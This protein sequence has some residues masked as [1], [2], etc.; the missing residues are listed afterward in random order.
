M[1]EMLSSLADLHDDDRFGLF[2][3]SDCCDSDEERGEIGSD[4]VTPAIAQ[5]PNTRQG[6]LAGLSSPLWQHVNWS[7][8]ETDSSTATS[9]ASETSSKLNIQPTLI[10]TVAA[11]D[12]ASLP[13]PPPFARFNRA[14]RRNHVLNID[15]VSDISDEDDGD[16][17]EQL[18]SRKPSRRR[19]HRIHWTPLRGLTL[20]F[21]VTAY[22]I[23]GIS[24]DDIATELVVHNNLLIV[25]EYAATVSANATLIAGAPKTNALRSVTE[26]HALPLQQHNVVNQQPKLQFAVRQQQPLNH[27]HL[28]FKQQAEMERFYHQPAILHSSTPGRLYYAVALLGVVAWAVRLYTM[29]VSWSAGAFKR[30]YGSA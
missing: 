19:G 3:V 23:F 11:T 6:S 14:R 5:T 13:S 12:L 27:H 8:T 1:T 10:A 18:Y 21:F 4:F 16:D 29:Q 15:D 26:N 30:S 22:T 9:C 7:L 25:P 2:I 24:D 17:A 20:L 28:T